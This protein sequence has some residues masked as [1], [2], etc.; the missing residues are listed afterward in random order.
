MRPRDAGLALFVL[1]GACVEQNDAWDPPGATDTDASSSSGTEPMPPRAE[2]TS[3]GADASS[4][5]GF[6]GSSSTSSTGGETSTGTE[7]A[8]TESAPP[9]ECPG[10]WNH[11]CAGEC[12]DVKRDPL[13]CG[14]DCVDCTATMGAD[15]TCH[16][17]TCRAPEGDEGG[18]EPDDD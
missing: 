10:F 15:A 6:D 16:Q 11:A 17:G 7:D 9:L 13:R 14:H 4:S 1:L 8:D 12:V 2:V 3:D 5:T 18:D